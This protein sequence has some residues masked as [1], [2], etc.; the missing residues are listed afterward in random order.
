MVQAIEF[1]IIS[2]ND[3]RKAYKDRI[4]ERVA[5]PEARI[6]SV[7]ALTGDLRQLLQERNARLPDWVYKRGEIGIWLSN[8]DCWK[9]S[10][11][12]NVP[13]IVFE[14]DAIPEPDFMIKFNIY[15]RNLPDDWDFVALWVPSEQYRHYTESVVF[16]ENGRELVLHS[17]VSIYDY[18]AKYL[19]KSYQGFGGVAIMYSPAGAEKL[20]NT[21]EEKGLFTTCDCAVMFESWRN[22]INGYAPKPKYANLV[23]Y[24]Y[25]PTTIHNSEKYYG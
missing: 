20:L 19:A 15:M 11:E 14:D 9:Y 22:R 12:N 6:P 10:L 7:N 24:D 17:P 21:V 2:I 8:I 23:R 13:L 16:E 5:F 18:D 4:R 3:V 25:A 1:N